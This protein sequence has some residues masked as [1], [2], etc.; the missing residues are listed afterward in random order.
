MRKDGNAMSMWSITRWQLIPMPLKISTCRMNKRSW[1]RLFIFI[2]TSMKSNRFRR[3]QKKTREAKQSEQIILKRH[4][5]WNKNIWIILSIYRSRIFNKKK[6]KIS[7]I[8]INCVITS[9]GDDK[10][11]KNKCIRICRPLQCFWK[12]YETK[13][14]M[15]LI[16]KNKQKKN[17]IMKSQW[18]I[19]QLIWSHLGLEL[20]KKACRAW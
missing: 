10:L 8:M 17:Q 6:P 11:W 14:R 5:I 9:I 15:G 20:F 7:Q 4:L 18:W 2:G 19:I 16:H 1:T 12:L 3:S 13:I